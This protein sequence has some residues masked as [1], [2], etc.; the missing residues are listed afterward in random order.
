MN[1][2]TNIQSV[3]IQYL[4]VDEINDIKTINKTFYNDLIKNK[5][6]I[7]DMIDKK[8]L[9]N[10]EIFYIIIYQLLLQIFF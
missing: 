7:K 3:I 2:S 6:V 10:K 9:L 1:I 8:N 4:T 5:K